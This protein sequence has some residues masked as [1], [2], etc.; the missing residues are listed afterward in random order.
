MAGAMQASGGTPEV[1][2]KELYDSILDSRMETLP[3]GTYHMGYTGDIGSMA[4]HMEK[5]FRFMELGFSEKEVLRMA[6]MLPPEE[7]DY[8]LYKKIISSSAVQLDRMREE[9][10]RKFGKINLVSFQGEGRNTTVRM[11]ALTARYALWALQRGSNVPLSKE[12]HINW[13]SKLLS[14]FS[15]EKL[16][17]LNPSDGDF[18]DI[19]KIAKLCMVTESRLEREESGFHDRYQLLLKAAELYLKIGDA[20]NAL[21]CTER[22]ITVDGASSA[23]TREYLLGL[24][25]IGNILLKVGK[26]R[27]SLS[28]YQQASRVLEY[29]YGNLEEM[30]AEDVVDT[31]DDEWDQR[32]YAVI[33]GQIGLIYG[34]LG[35]RQ[36]ALEYQVKALEIRK[37]VLP[38]THPD[39]AIS[40]NN[41]GGD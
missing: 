5:I 24:G 31:I 2:L 3:Q 28:Y 30:S 21:E 15:D 16:E 35:D 20:K 11:H 18:K 13:T 34:Y 37:K 41:V 1:S 4:W 12:V 25:E 29:K 9:I 7:M 6:A 36:R 38:E 23:D 17:K 33:C 39:L 27:E 40:Y 32:N 10:I 8:E 22:A 26:Y 14:Y 19:A